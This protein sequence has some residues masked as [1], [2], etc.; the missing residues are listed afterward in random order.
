M[1]ALSLVFDLISR[2]RA[3]DGIRA[4][5]D[6]ADKSG[7]RLGKLGAA[8]AA[9]LGGVL[10][11][12]AA[13]GLGAVK[14]FAA[15]AVDAFAAVEDATG[16]AGV[17]FGKALPDVLK[18]ADNAAKSFG[19]SRREALEAQNTFGTFGKAA[20]LSGGDLSGFSGK[21]AGLAGD[22]ASFKGTSVEQAIG[23]IGSALK[24]EADPIEAF[25][26]QMNAAAIQAEALS[27]GLIKT[28]KEALTPQQ[29]T[30]AVTA[31]LFKSTKDA[32]GD[33]ARTSD[34]T[35]NT[36]KTLAAELENAQVALGEKLAPALTIGRR[37]LLEFTKGAAGVFDAIG[38]ALDFATKAFSVFI[39]AI[40][41]GGKGEFDGFL[42]AVN[43]VGATISED[44]VPAI[45]SFVSEMSERLQPVLATVGGFIKDNI[46][47]ILAVLGGVLGGVVLSAAVALAGVVGGALVTA[48]GAVAAVLLSPLAIL[49]ALAGALTIAYKESENFQIAVDL[50]VKTFKRAFEIFQ[51]KG[52]IEALKFL[53]DNLGDIVK[54]FGPVLL[55]ELT[56]AG[57]KLVD[58][59]AP[60]IPPLL[61]K[62]R[63][64]GATIFDFFT[65]TVLPTLG[66]TLGT[67]GEE[68]V[69][70][71]G[72]R[73]G[74]LLKKLGELAASLFTFL[75]ETVLPALVEKLTELG[76]ALLD[77]IGPRIGPLLL[78]LGKLLASLTRYLIETALPAIISKVAEWGA[79]IIG[80]VGPAAVKLVG[81]LVELIADVGGYLGG[82]ALTAIKNKAEDFGEGIIDGIMRGLKKTANS[83]GEFV[84][85]LIDKL[86]GISFD[87]KGK[88]E[89]DGPGAGGVVR[90]GST[91]ARVAGIVQSFGAGISSTYRTPARNRA[92]GGSPSSYHMDKANPAVDIVGTTAQLDAIYARLVRSGPWRELLWRVPNHAPGDNPHI[93]VAH[94]GA[95][96]DSSWQ[97]LPG[98]R[99]D[100]RP[101]V[102]QVGE[103]VTPAGGMEDVIAALARVEAAIVRET[104]RRVLLA[105]S[106]A[107]AGAF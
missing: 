53:F 1:A 68:L 81:K 45:K 101:A 24:G 49:G 72:P 92:V 77:W 22:L 105:R 9:G 63:E 74:P 47:P 102:L 99:S 54:R 89:G 25:G 88:N 71:V 64:V 18:F 97:S 80:W 26:V 36:A 106:G 60:R 20:G 51:D 10:G 62:L 5:G 19:I 46:Q 35:A 85:K 70:W 44:I 3:S 66:R 90:G 56:A 98:M 94:R 33:Y 65:D 7:G 38:P 67:I 32:Q 50:V 57:R 11:G 103:V 76:G 43:D 100:E 21:L 16:A 87:V 34:G 29:K 69:K 55:E 86:P 31:L 104:D 23:A 40:K 27:Q 8:A 52:P 6:A 13:S 82:K 91:Q 2:D 95:R 12:A 28:T 79:A 83:I 73:I 61:A 42:G 48:L 75:A 41:F 39:D 93:H 30:L 14:N 96:V 4:V 107:M 78:E 37:V 15:G 84:V 17:Q 58:W 59:V